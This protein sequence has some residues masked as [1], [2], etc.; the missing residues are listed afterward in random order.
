MIME[1]LR[2]IRIFFNSIMMRYM[3]YRENE[4]N[5]YHHPLLADDYTSIAVKPHEHILSPS[6]RARSRTQSSN[7][8][9]TTAVGR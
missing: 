9:C 2:Y 5:N 7:F 1:S 6:L 4:N 8:P 3:N